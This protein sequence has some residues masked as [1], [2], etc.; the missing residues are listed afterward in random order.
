MGMEFLQG[1][2]QTTVQDLGRR[3]YQ[4]YGFPISG[5]MDLRSASLAN[6]L[7][8]N[9]VEEAVLEI[10]PQGPEILCT[11]PAYIALTGGQMDVTCDGQK[12]PF[13]QTFWVETKQILRFG[14]LHA[15]A[16]CYLAVA[17]GFQLNP[18]IGSCST[19]LL[20]GIGGMEG[21]ALRKGD[22]LTFRKWAQTQDY[23]KAPRSLPP[24]DFSPKEKKLRVVAGPQETSFTPQGLT[25]FFQTPYQ[26][27]EKHDRNSYRLKG[28]PIEFVPSP[29]FI[30]EGITFGS[31]QVQE[32]GQPEVLMADCQTVEG[33]AKIAAVITVDLPLLAQGKPGDVFRFEQ[34][35]IQEAQDLYCHWLD[36]LKQLQFYQ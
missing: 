6:L 18:V 29:H 32:D 4:Q 30:S 17:G 10:T 36:Q 2:T 34:I 1:G 33:L 25:T 3:G 9:G 24:E 26:V 31:I 5:V 7:V 19:F 21:R 35:P 14:R 13:Y 22:S 15:G 20:G 16:R 8:G 28:A 11:A 12:V 23:F 27:T